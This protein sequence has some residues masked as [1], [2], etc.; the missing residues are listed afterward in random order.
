MTELDEDVLNAMRVQGEKLLVDDFVF[1]LEEHHRNDD[2]D[3]PGVSRSLIEAYAEHLSADVEMMLDPDALLAAIDDR[4]INGETW[5]D[6]NAVYSVGSD[7]VS[8]FPQQWHEKLRGSTDLR[9]YVE[10]MS[11][12]VTTPDTEPGIRRQQV[13]DAAAIFAG[14]DRDE[15]LERLTELR[16]EGQLASD[17]DQ[18]PESNVYIPNKIG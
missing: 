13:V 4:L 10:V 14:M 1:L 7:R 2:G 9:S 17:A 8:V 15:A 12:D 5:S 18:N 6:E 3:K 16:W 11:E